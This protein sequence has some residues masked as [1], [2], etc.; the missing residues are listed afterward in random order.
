M[1]HPIRWKEREK[2]AA[3]RG[4]PTAVPLAGSY[5]NGA[6][7]SIRRPCV[8]LIDTQHLIYHRRHRTHTHTVD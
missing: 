3:S 4:T 1:L 5:P 2:R 8:E 7:A 6:R